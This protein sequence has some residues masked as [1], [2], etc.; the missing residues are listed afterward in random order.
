MRPLIPL[1][2]VAAT[3]VIVVSPAT[4]HF[5]TGSYTHSGC[6]ATS[7]NR[8]DPI[9]FVFWDWGTIGR[10]ENSIDYHAGWTN[11]SGSNQT[12]LDHGNC[13][14]MAAQHAS[15]CGTCSRYHIR[16]HPIHFDD[17]LRWTTVGDAHHEDWV[18][19]CGHAVDKNGPEGSGF[20][21]GRKQLRVKLQN[22]GHDWW[23]EWWGNT[24]PFK[25]CDGDVASSDGYTVFSR[26]HQLFH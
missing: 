14:N 2:A 16:L 5:T 21:Q 11:G 18:W 10:A 15:G 26:T 25:Q 9:N 6:P 8:V 23:S 17:V 19:Y 3:L 20:D 12:F 7:S 24:Q 4:A 13:Y 1:I 22:G